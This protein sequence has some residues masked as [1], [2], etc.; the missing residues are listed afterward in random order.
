LNIKLIQDLHRS[1]GS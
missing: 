1:W